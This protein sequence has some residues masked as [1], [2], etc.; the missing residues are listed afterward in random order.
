MSET[1]I[2]TYGFKPYSSE[3]KTKSLFLS[4]GLSEKSYNNS[5]SISSIT[6]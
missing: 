2:E 4:S 1:L 5:K 3:G 6:I